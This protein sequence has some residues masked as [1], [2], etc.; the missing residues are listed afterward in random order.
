[1]TATGEPAAITPDTKDWTWVVEQGCPECGWHAPAATAVAGRVEATIPR[2]ADVLERPGAGERTDP[3]TWS[4]LEYGCHVRDVCV[5]FGVRLARMLAE[6]DPTF[7]DW[8]QD[9]AAQADRYHTQ[10]P[11]T[12][13]GEYAEAARHTAALFAGVTGEAWQRRGTRSNGSVFTVATL[14]TY[15]L[16]DLEHHLADVDG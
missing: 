11:A 12:V 5:V 6:D 13:A 3:T 7:A 10:D 15:F 8:D 16:H 4:A 9:A 1:M 2:W 14:A